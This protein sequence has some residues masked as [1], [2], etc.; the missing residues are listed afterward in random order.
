MERAILLLYD[1]TGN[2][3]IRIRDRSDLNL[4]LPPVALIILKLGIIKV[5]VSKWSSKKSVMKLLRFES[6]QDFMFY[7]PFV[8]RNHFRN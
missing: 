6:R 2:N 5:A 8:K 1:N 4:C 3:P 7:L